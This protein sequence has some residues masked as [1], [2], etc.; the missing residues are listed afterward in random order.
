MVDGNSTDGTVEKAKRF[1]VEII[2]ESGRGSPSNARN[3]GAQASSGEI[4]F[5]LDADV[6]PAKD[7][8]ENALNYF[9]NSRARI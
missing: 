1:P 9:K 2:R 7:C 5:F 8:I 4:L 3:L 6:E